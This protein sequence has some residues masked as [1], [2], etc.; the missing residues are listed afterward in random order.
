MQGKEIA[1]VTNDTAETSITY[2]IHHH[3]TPH[4]MVIC[5]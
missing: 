4:E 1:Y 3:T 2:H 5:E